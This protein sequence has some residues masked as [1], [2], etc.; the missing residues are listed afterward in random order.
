MLAASWTD[1]ADELARWRDAG[2]LVEFWWRDDDAGAQSASLRRLISLAS[3]AGV[4]L[5][6]AA[7]PADAERAALANLPP[8]VTV[9]QHGADHRN[10]AAGGEKKTEFPPSEP[11]DLALERLVAGRK[12]L[13]GAAG[14]PVLTVLAPPWNRISTALAARLAGAGYRGLSRFGVRKVTLPGA[15]PTEVNT[16]VDI[17]D[18]HGRRGFCGTAQALGEAV[19]HLAS[20]RL[21]ES[22][23]AEPTGWLTHH[24]VH[25]EQCWDFLEK[26]FD[27]TRMNAGVAWLAPAKVFEIESGSKSTPA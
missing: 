5:A 1:L 16:H 10:R 25:D 7:V 24:A 4:P 27:S 11:V 13:E 26:L 9:I 21:G 19:R 22:D 2:K 17:I 23:A 12:K 3:S 14:G 18:W 15:A 20:R 6:L 8:A